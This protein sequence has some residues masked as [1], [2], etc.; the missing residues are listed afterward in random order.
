MNFLCCFFL[1]GVSSA[2]TS[3]AQ[4]QPATNQIGTSNIQN[5]I[6]NDN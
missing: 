6:E 2:G 5:R 1:A 4:P 3:A